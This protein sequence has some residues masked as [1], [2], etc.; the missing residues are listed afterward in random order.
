MVKR[1]VILYFSSQFFSLILQVVVQQCFHQMYQ[2]H[3][4]NAPDANGRY[5]AGTSADVS[6]DGGYEL[7]GSKSV[8]CGHSPYGIWSDPIER[9]R[10]IPSDQSEYFK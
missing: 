4:A 3:L 2:F 10:C 6:C 9:F 7:Y 5:R 1:K 8:Y